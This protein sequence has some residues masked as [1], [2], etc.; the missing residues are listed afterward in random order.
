MF[1]NKQFRYFTLLS[2]ILKFRIF[3]MFNYLYRETNECRSWKTF[4]L[5]LVGNASGFIEVGQSFN[6]KAIW[7]YKK[8]TRNIFNYS[9][10]I[11]STKSYILYNLI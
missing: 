3:Q 8:N 4:R 2:F 6:R 5:D 1:K 10:F 7:Y 11:Q 9:E